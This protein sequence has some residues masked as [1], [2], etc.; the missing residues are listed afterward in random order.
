MDGPDLYWNGPDG[1]TSIRLLRTAVDMGIELFDTSN[2]YGSGQSE[3]V[4]GEAVAGQRDKVVIVTKFGH[5]MDETTRTFMRTMNSP[6]PNGYAWGNLFPGMIRWQC[7]QSLRRLKTDYIDSFLC[8]VGKAENG[9]EMITRTA[10]RIPGTWMA[11][12]RTASRTWSSS[13]C[14]T[15]TATSRCSWC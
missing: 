1:S 5:R 7:E 2:V 11:T 13:I 4:L 10:R 6:V 12:S 14:A 9:E 15:T 3:E 8:H